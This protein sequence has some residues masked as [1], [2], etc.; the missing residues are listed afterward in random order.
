MT[1]LSTSIKLLISKARDSATQA[2]SV[3]NDPRSTFRTGNFTVLMTIAWTALLH[4][5]FEKQKIK[6]F[7][8]QPNGRYIKI[9]DER[10]AWELGESVKQVFDEND[11]IR[12][13]IELF[14][15]LRNKIEHRNLPGI[16]NE[17]IGEC[18]ALVLNFESWLVEKYG[19]IHSLIDTMFVPIQLTSSR[20]I[21]PKSKAEQRVIE[22]IKSYRNIL[23]PDIINSQQFS[24]KAFLVPKIGNHRS[25]SDI[26]IEFVKYDE[27]NSKEMEKYEKAIV[28]IKEKHIPVVN[29]DLYKPSDVLRELDRKGL[30]K[31]MCWH[32]T[33]WQK[34]KVRPSS[35]VKA[36]TNTK[37]DFCIYDKA[38][39][40]Y[41][42]TT[43][44]IDLLYN[45][46]GK[47]QGKTKEAA[48]AAPARSK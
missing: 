10:K 14:L 26:A 41:L 32:T 22:F 36:K 4:S 24:F 1:R 9:D 30:K 23:A 19:S 3:F 40:D 28:A 46:Q 11:P 25:S 44:W 33:M 15:K 45:P 13:N 34:F 35:S 37:S 8:K 5:Y 29:T 27:S 7:Y 16:D 47:T 38:H 6:Y 17:L 12:K 18:Q 43:K 39:R 21:L 2:V 20:R 42:Y 48:S 31:T